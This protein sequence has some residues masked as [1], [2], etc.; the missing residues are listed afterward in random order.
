MQGLSL[1]GVAIGIFVSVLLGIGQYEE[2]YVGW[3]GLDRISQTQVSNIVSSD[4]LDNYVLDSKSEE[5]PRFSTLS[6]RPDKTNHY[7]STGNSIRGIF[8]FKTPV[9]DDAI[10]MCDKT[11]IYKNINNNWTT[12]ES[13]FSDNPW[14]GVLWADPNVTRQYLTN[15]RETPRK[16]LTSGIYHM[17]NQDDIAPLTGNVKF[18]AGT[19]VATADSSVISGLSAG[20]YIIYTSTEAASQFDWNEIVSIEGNSL[21][22][23]T[24]TF[25][26]SQSATCYRSSDVVNARHMLEYEGHLVMAYTNIS[27]ETSV[28]NAPIS[29]YYIMGQGV[30]GIAQSFVAAK[31]TLKAITLK[32]GCDDNIYTGNLILKIRNTLTSEALATVNYPIGSLPASPQEVRF[33]FGNLVT[34]IG[35]TY[36]LTIEKSLGSADGSPVKIYLGTNLTGHS[37]WTYNANGFDNNYNVGITTIEVRPHDDIAQDACDTYLDKNS[38]DTNYY[39]AN[40]LYMRF[41]L[42]A[43]TQV[44]VLKDMV[45]PHT[46]GPSIKGSSSVFTNVKLQYWSQQSSTV[47]DLLDRVTAASDLSTATWNNLASNYTTVGETYVPQVSWP[48][49]QIATADVTAIYNSDTLFNGHMQGGIMISKRS[50]TTGNNWI[51]SSNIPV[52]TEQIPIWRYTV[53]MGSSEAGED[54]YLKVMSD[55]A[56]SSTVVYSRR[57]TP[58]L[59]PTLDTFQ[60]VGSIVGLAKSG[61]YLFV[62]TKNPDGMSVFRETGEEYDPNNGIP[63][64]LAIDQVTRINGIT[65][66]SAKSIAYT[67]M[68]DSFIFF[69][70]FGVYKQT[71]LQTT[72]LSG[73]IREEAKLFSNYRDPRDYYSGLADLMPQA[74]ILPTKDTYLLSVPNDQATNS[75]IYNYNYAQD[76]WTRWTQLHATSL[77]A[78]ETGG[79][80]PQLFMGDTNG[81]LSSLNSTGS[82]TDEAITECFFSKD[83]TKDKQLSLIEVW[84]RA[85]NPTVNSLFTIE[86]T[87]INVPQGPASQTFVTNNVTTDG[88][89]QFSFNPNM[90]AK[91]FKIRMTQKAQVGALSLRSVRYKYSVIQTR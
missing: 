21:I 31:P 16:Y 9:G 3:K 53:P 84:A 18:T 48:S 54:L 89:V 72:L 47:D 25:T 39:Q 24:P 22:F 6:V 63:D 50:A 69:S 64:G 74:C 59:F 67:P 15:G 80:E 46:E 27:T 68:D 86:V 7:R 58:E 29:N 11:S 91:E 56:D 19:L 14:E 87:S 52:H 57:Y 76:G 41:Q 23:S 10:I 40:N 77:L 82:T 45:Y 26:T 12:L 35:N 30:T 81:Q 55:S 75:Y 78:K 34:A 49:Y 8:N 51:N 4:Q 71:G 85:D 61:G 43:R 20:E 62:A 1:I 60:V 44:A 42:A 37:Y 90:T 65:F 2:V 33:D 32:I 13:G 70:G 36:Y 66:G 5:N 38:P 79:L 17:Q 83:I 73:N 28:S 88:M